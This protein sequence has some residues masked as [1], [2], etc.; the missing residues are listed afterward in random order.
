[1]AITLNRDKFGQEERQKI[2]ALL[3]KLRPFVQSNRQAAHLYKTGK[4]LAEDLEEFLA[5]A[6]AKLTAVPP[7]EIEDCRYRWNP[8]C[9]NA[10][11][12]AASALINRG[13]KWK[14]RAQTLMAR[15]TNRRAREC[16]KQK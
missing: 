3:A 2:A 16:M 4:H 9:Q 13:K 15:I 6:P 5:L 10:P 12:E 14:E 7:P 11:A 1:M 8:Y